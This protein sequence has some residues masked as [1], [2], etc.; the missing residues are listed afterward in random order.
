MTPQTAALSGVF[1]DSGLIAELRDDH[2]TLKQQ[3]K[4][5]NHFIASRQID[6][7]KQLLE[8]FKSTLIAHVYREN[9]KLYI[10]LQASLR[11]NPQEIVKMRILRKEMDA[12]SVMV[13]DFLD[14][15]ES[16]GQKMH[17][18]VNFITDFMVVRSMYLKRIQRESDELFPMYRPP[19]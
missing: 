16:V 9:L 2:R 6:K 17:L 11:R 3:L 10:Y 19:Q 8:R 4:L 15:Y 13:M 1:Y 18:Q 12:I 7:V 5:I 14:K